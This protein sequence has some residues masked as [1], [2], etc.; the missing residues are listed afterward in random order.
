MSAINSTSPVPGTIT[1]FHI[2]DNEKQL[3]VFLVVLVAWH[4]LKNTSG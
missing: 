1:G 2:A 3:T 4:L